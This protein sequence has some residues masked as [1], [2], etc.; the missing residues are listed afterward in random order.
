MDDNWHAIYTERAATA[1]P[2]HEKSCWTKKG[3]ED[4]FKLF[5][6]LV[7]RFGPFESSLD[8]GCGYG[9]YCRYLADI[10]LSRVV[11]V[12]YAADVA[13]AAKKKHP[14]L[15]L[16]IA[17]GYALPF[18][19]RSFDLVF[20]IGALQCVKEYKRFTAELSRVAAKTVI[21]S[22][23]RR[24]HRADPD[25]ELQKMLHYDSWPTRSY[26]PDDII[27]L[28]EKEGFVVELFTDDINGQMLDDCF[29]LVARRL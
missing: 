1:R 16:R 20:S 13:T 25:V 29:F 11:G 12:D 10:G 19:D 21:I 7:E 4:R 28:F 26:H 5:A 24:A 3:F 27:S 17:N 14:D 15:D 9:A 8:V 22:T 2:E 18:A 23:L 6:T